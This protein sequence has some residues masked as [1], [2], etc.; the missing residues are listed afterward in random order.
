[1]VVI[2]TLGRHCHFVTV[3]VLVVNK[4]GSVLCQVVV[5]V[6][7]VVTVIMLV[8]VCMIVIVKIRQIL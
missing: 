6:S 3:T 7:M 1:M 5:I 2:V 4:H 8:I